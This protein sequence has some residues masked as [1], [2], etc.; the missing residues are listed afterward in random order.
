MAKKS[1]V[2]KNNRRKRIV[3]RDMA[4]RKA[5]KDIIMNKSIPLE[6]RFAAQLKIAQMPR[7]GAANRVRN[8]CEL[9]GRARGFVGKF[10]VSRICIRYLAGRGMLPGVIKSSW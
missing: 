5:L 4:K 8:R 6:E 9:T 3:I 7:D 10:K 2:E 1:S